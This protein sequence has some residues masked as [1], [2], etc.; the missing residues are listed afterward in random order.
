MTTS[1]E[2]AADAGEVGGEGPT[3][4]SMLELL[5]GRTQQGAAAEGMHPGVFSWPQAL[6]APS[7]SA[8]CPCSGG[9]AG[10]A[11][12]VLPAHAGFAWG[13]RGVCRAGFAWWHLQIWVCMAGFAQ[14]GWHGGVCMEGKG[15]SACK[16]VPQCQQQRTGERGTVS[17]ALCR[18]EPVPEKGP[19]LSLLICMTV[20][21]RLLQ[22]G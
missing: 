17:P 10:M 8:H 12:L 18:R 21:T 4:T 20:A 2:T 16:A 6:P 5:H 19:L 22:H 9:Q 1:L 7:Y 3:D 14:E 13:G 11:V 15:L